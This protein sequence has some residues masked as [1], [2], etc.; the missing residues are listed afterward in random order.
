MFGKFPQK[1]L[2]TL[3][4]KNQNQVKEQICLKYANVCHL[5][6]PLLPSVPSLVF[7]FIV[8]INVYVF[9]F[10]WERVRNTDSCHLSAGSF[11]ICL[12]Q[13]WVG[14]AKPRTRDCFRVWHSS[15][16]SSDTGPAFTA[17]PRLWAGSW[18]RKTSSTRKGCHL[19]NNYSTCHTSTLAPL[20]FF[21][22]QV[23]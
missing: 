2:L 21:I 10:H 6:Q 8:F 18:L 5:H 1:S 14:Q 7:L 17:L 3:L 12:Q 16:K 22:V 15:G 11:L 4:W 13:P 9:I 23:A 19:H 20:L